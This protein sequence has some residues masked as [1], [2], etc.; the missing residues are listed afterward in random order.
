MPNQFQIAMKIMDFLNNLKKE[1]TPEQ[2]AALI[3]FDIIDNDGWNT[4]EAFN[5]PCD[6]ATF[7]EKANRCTIGPIR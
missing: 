2:W 7:V 3:G 6:L 5:S 1:H 4:R